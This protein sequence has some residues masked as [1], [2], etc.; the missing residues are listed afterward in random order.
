MAS[1]L[2]QPPHHEAAVFEILDHQE[3]VLASH[4]PTRYF[5]VCHCDAL[6]RISSER[7]V[8]FVN[9]SHENATQKV[10]SIG[11][12]SYSFGASL[13][14]LYMKRAF[15]TPSDASGL[16]D[17]GRATLRIVHDI[18]NH[19]NG[20]KLY[21]T[22]LSKRLEERDRSEEERETVAKLIAGLDRA[23][24][25]MDALV[26]YAQ[27][28]ELRR[29]ARSDLKKIVLKAAR[30]PAYKVS[31][32][33]ADNVPCEIQGSLTGAFDSHLLAHAFS[34]LTREALAGARASDRPGLTLCARRMGANGS[35]KAVV[36]WRGVKPRVRDAE[37][38]MHATFA[39]RVIN[40]HGGRIQFLRDI[41]RVTLPLL[42]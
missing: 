6:A 7:G 9:M 3:G 17:L 14:P 1:H 32:P 28:L 15:P 40:A 24:K 13:Q 34:A 10:N 25:E 8:P 37:P 19:L 16:E 18:K 23:A 5:I 30:D 27:P 21:A 29:Q 33:L 41:I 4:F 22:F 35:P 12:N 26:R 38:S 20:L 42:D 2:E 11:S 39:K 31:G 36:E